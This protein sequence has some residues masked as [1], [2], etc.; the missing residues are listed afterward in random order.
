M[1]WILTYPRCLY[2]FTTYLLMELTYCIC[3]RNWLSFFILIDSSVSFFIPHLNTLPILP[4]FHFFCIFLYF[5]FINFQ[6]NKEFD[7]YQGVAMIWIL[8]NRNFNSVL[9]KICFWF[10]QSLLY[11]KLV[12]E[13]IRTTGSDKCWSQTGIDLQLQGSYIHGYGP[14]CTMW[15]MLKW[16]DPLLSRVGQYQH[17]GL[18]TV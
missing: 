13:T 1:I 11:Y 15:T 7:G 12:Y 6:K 5:S 14:K 18:G 16:R 10:E 4:F 8:V 9:K 17:K 3:Y 2:V